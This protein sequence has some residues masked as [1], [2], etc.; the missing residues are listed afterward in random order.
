M[1]PYSVVVADVNGDN[2]PDLVVINNPG[3]SV[4]VFFGNGDG[5]FQAA[6]NFL[7]RLVSACALAVTD[8]NGDL[9]TSILSSSMNLAAQ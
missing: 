3:N 5:T 1:G 8:V 4:S 7:R 2:K 9:T 6:V